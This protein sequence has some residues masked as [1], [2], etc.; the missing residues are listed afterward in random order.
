MMLKGGAIISVNGGEL[1]AEIAERV[2]F[3]IVLNFR[4]PEFFV[5]DEINPF[6]A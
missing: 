3:I 6:I 4:A 1:V 2:L 5:A